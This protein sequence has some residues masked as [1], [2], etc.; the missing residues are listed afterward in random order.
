MTHRTTPHFW[1]CY[2][3]LPER[4]QNLA[5]QKFELLES[6]PRHPSL[7]LKKV[8]DQLW[9]V[10]VGLRYRA[11][12]TLSESDLIWFWI[13]SHAEYDDILLRS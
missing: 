2:Q 6:N 8:T 11:L 5:D 12:A 7:R 1:K 13:G 4:V 9:S 3:N 10:R